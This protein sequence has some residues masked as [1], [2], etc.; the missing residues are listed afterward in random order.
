[1][2]DVVSGQITEFAIPGSKPQPVGI[3]RGPD[4]HLWITDRGDA[5]IGEVNIG[6]TSHSSTVTAQAA[7][8]LKNERKLTGLQTTF[9]GHLD[10]STATNVAGYQLGRIQKG[11]TGK[12][13][14]LVG[15]S[16][17]SYNASTNSVTLIPPE[18]LKPGVYRL[19]ILSS[20]SGGV[21]DASGQ[22]LAGGDASLSPRV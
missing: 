5:S 4:G 9:S 20:S 6:S 16:S 18:K 13:P 7:V 15:L 8:F 12:S 10:P 14:V 21:L 11:H 2:L 19:V 3:T 1:M 22:P 17:P